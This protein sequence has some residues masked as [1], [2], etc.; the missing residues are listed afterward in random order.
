MPI[1]NFDGETY[2]AYIDISGFKELMQDE[3]RALRALDRLY[4][5][6]YDII[7]D[8]NDDFKVDATN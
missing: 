2:V 6:G 7:R 5:T 3:E 8:Q 4:Q 1:N